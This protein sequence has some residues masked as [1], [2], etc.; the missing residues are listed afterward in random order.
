MAFSRK[1][2]Y[3]G[4]RKA[5][6]RTG[7]DAAGGDSRTGGRTR[8]HR[9][10]G[11]DHGLGARAN[12]SESTQLRDALFA[13]CETME[14]TQTTLKEAFD[15]YDRN[16]SGTIS[17]AEFTRLIRALGGLGLTKRQVYVRRGRVCVGEG[18]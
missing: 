17:I 1:T 10:E 12:D 18:V 13:I 8:R 4:L 14:K 16:G 6:T 11:G 15:A 5:V 2:T 3:T 7:N 9:P